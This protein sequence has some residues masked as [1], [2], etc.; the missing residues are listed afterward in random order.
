MFGKFI[1]QTKGIFMRQVFRSATAFILLSSPV[2]AIAGGAGFGGPYIGVNV[3]YDKYKLKETAMFDDGVLPASYSASDSK[4]GFYAEA[5]GGYNYS[6]GSVVVIGAEA[7]FGN[8]FGKQVG[9]AITD[10]AS[11]DSFS[12][13]AKPKWNAGI[14]AR[15]GFIVAKDYLIYEFVGYELAHYSGGSELRFA[16][17]LDTTTSGSKNLSGLKIGLGVEARV[18]NHMSARLEFTHVKYGSKV[19][20]SC[21]PACNGFSSYSVNGTRNR[22]T[23]GMA[24]HF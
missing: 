14:N 10:I 15:L 24:Y 22:F 17:V 21:T 11:G 13:F 2:A 20:D 7:G 19:L 18:S 12:A 16:N 23:Y 3:G 8:V 1:I 4:G 5:I 9:Y 6:L